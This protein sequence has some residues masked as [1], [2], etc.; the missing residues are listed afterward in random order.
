MMLYGI[1]ESFFYDVTSLLLSCSVHHVLSCTFLI[2]SRVE[3]KIS[4][5]AQTHTLT[6]SFQDKFL[7]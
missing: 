3:M 2:D 6:Q 7:L 1:S 5:T 4:Q